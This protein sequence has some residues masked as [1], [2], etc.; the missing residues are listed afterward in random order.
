MTPMSHPLWFLFVQGILIFISFRIP[1]RSTKRSYV[2]R[3]DAG[4]PG[5]AAL[6]AQPPAAEM[7]AAQAGGVVKGKRWKGKGATQRK[8]RE[9]EGTNINKVPRPSF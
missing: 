2:P 4:H 6:L 7:R 9:T 8:L 5:P 3:A 1:C